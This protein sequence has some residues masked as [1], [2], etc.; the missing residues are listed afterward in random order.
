MSHHRG[1]LRYAERAFRR[2]DDASPEPALSVVF[3]VNAMTHGDIDHLPVA[4]DEPEEVW[5][6]VA[7]YVV[8]WNLVELVGDTPQSVPPPAEAGPDVCRH[9]TIQET[10]WLLEVIRHAH[11]ATVLGEEDRS[12]SLAGFGCMHASGVARNSAG[13]TSRSDRSR[14]TGPTIAIGAWM[15]WGQPPG[16]VSMPMTTSSPLTSIRH[17]RTALMMPTANRAQLRPSTI[18]TN[19]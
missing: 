10:Y 15:R 3:P 13:R 7:P 4:S 6:A 18:A 5:E 11:L 19:V 9:L 17:G 16:G 1:A 8:A 2:E 12:K 14:W